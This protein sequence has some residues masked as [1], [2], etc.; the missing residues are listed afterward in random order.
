MILEKLTIN[1]YFQ[2]IEIN[3]FIV[4]IRLEGSI[5]ERI[6]CNPNS[7]FEYALA[8]VKMVKSVM[9]PLL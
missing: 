1:V 7:S 3:Q 9:F 8:L 2:S 5:M 4:F 6:N